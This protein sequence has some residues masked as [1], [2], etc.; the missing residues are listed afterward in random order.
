[1][2]YKYPYFCR[3]IKISTLIKNVF[4]IIVTYN[5]SKYVEKCIESL[6]ESAFPVGIVIVDNNSADN[7]VTL[8]KQYSQL[9][10]IESNENL[11]FGQANT[12]GT[13]YALENGADY[14][15]L[16]NQDTWIFKDT[17][18]N[19]VAAAEEN[20]QSGIISPMHFSADE[21]VLD[22]NFATYYNRSWDKDADNNVAKV[23]FVNAAAWLIPKKCLHRVGRFEKL[24][25]HYGEDRNFCDRVLYH[26]F[27]IIIAKHSKIC[28]DRTIAR[29][30]AKD[31]IQSEYILLSQVL[32]INNSL[33]ISYFLALKSAFG[34][35]KYYSKFYTFSKIAT[36]FLKLLI[37]YMGLIFSMSKIV[38]ARRQSKIV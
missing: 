1:M 7:T 2:N 28:H 24:F 33:I 21:N 27:E 22:V 30:F 9:H 35:P 37:C 29:Y 36:L 5:G 38:L 10:I 25:K 15:F 13:D 31:I 23:D 12:I 16:L 20:P 8:L 32:N 19:L 4:V 11:G 26:K 3:I 18:L 17:I 6:L 14:V 34:L